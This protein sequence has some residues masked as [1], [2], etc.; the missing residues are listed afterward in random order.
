MATLR[1]MPTLFLFV[2]NKIC[3]L[4]ALGFTYTYMSLIIASPQKISFLLMTLSW[5]LLLGR[6][7]NLSW[8]FVRP[9]HPSGD[10]SSTPPNQVSWFLVN[11][12]T[13]N[14]PSEILD[15][16]FLA[17][18]LFQKLMI[19]GILRS[20]S[21][22]SRPKIAERCSAGCS[23]FFTLSIV[24]FTQSPPSDS[25]PLSL[26]IL[27]CGSELWTLSQSDLLLISSVHHKILRTIQGLL[28]G[29]CDI[30]HL[31]QI[32]QL[33]FI[34]SLTNMSESDLPRQGLHARLKSPSR[35]GVIPRWEILLVQ[36][37]LPDI[38]SLV[39]RGGFNKQS[40]QRHCKK[41]ALISEHFSLLCLL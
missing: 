23:A 8:I 33:S 22:S 15:L 41:H 13:P 31:I 2:H 12:L 38:P 35:S 17:P 36:Y 10:T 4:W 32:R 29:S 21:N 18:L 30:G 39:A 28:V 19:T 1:A 34:S 14:L 7:C 25:I 6:G 9:M 27:I 5:W 40:W 24:V 11:L 16:G 26:P 20:L 3:V 37:K